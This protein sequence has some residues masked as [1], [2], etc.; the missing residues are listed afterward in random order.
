[1]IVA[2]DTDGAR[3]KW[4][5]IYA[6]ASSEAPQACL[7]LREYAGLLPPTGRALDVACG[8]G[9]NALLLAAHG[10]QTTAMDISCKALDLLRERTQSSGLGIELI[11]SDTADFAPG[12][13]LYDVIVVSNYLDR[14][15]CR[16][17]ESLMAP[18]GLLFYQ[19]FVKDK[20]DPARGPSRPEFLLD[21][22]ELLKLFPALRALVHVDLGRVGDLSHGLRDQAM[23]VALKESLSEQSQL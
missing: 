19:T 23:L 14:Y 22:G 17:I 1:M 8:H 10:L 3:Q 21:A 15:F 18:G 7:A 6:S 4:N 2:D 20:A 5:R 13:G 9:G 11:E 16:R 12:D